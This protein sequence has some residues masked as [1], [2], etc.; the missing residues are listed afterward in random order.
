[1][2]S[3]RIRDTLALSPPSVQP[4]THDI[5][6]RGPEIIFERVRRGDALN[7]I[8]EIPN[9]TDLYAPVAGEDGVVDQVTVN[10]HDAVPGP[11]GS[12]Q[13]MVIETK[14]TPGRRLRALMECINDKGFVRILETHS[15]LSGIIAENAT[16]ERDGST[17][18]YDGFWESSLTDSA[19]KGYPDASIVGNDSRIHTIDEILNVTSK[20]IIVDGDTG[21]DPAQFRYLVRHLERLG[22]SAV[23]I[24]DKVYPKRNSLDASASQ[25]LEDPEVFAS[26]IQAGREVRLSDDFLVIARLESLIAGVGLQDALDRAEQ[27][28]IAGADGIMIHSS[29]RDPEEILAFAEAYGPLCRRLGKRP[30]LVSVPTTYNSISDTELAAAGF[31]IVIHA[32]H[33]LRASHRAMK[34]VAQQILESDRSMEA[35]PF[36]TSTAEIFATVGFDLVTERDWKASLVQRLSVIIPAAGRDPAFPDTPKSLIQV[37]GR[38][39]LD[40][41]LEAVRRTGINKIVVVRG[42]EGQQFG[43]R[44]ADEEITLCENPRYEETFDLYSLFQAEQHMQRGFVLIYSDILFDHEIVQKLVDTGEDIVLA[45]DGSYQYHMH[46]IDKRLDLAISANRREVHHRSLQPAALTEISRL[47]K[48]IDR[49]VADYEFVGIAYFSEQGAKTLLDA[50]KDCQQTA[51]GAFHEAGSFNMASVTDLLQELINRDVTVHGLEIHKGWLEI[52]NQHDIAVAESEMLPMAP[53][54]LVAD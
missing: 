42:H 25:S 15:G 7:D 41:Q 28:I 14:V 49:E 11:K 3:L 17:L 40:Y 53:A 37:A 20:P 24:E 38:H 22:V 43:T 27:Y 26:K 31:N 4:S 1:M 5:S 54:V 19:T 16:V 21:G 46:E 51:R 36:I 32:N 8:S 10:H 52:H 29:K 12:E 48:D 33:M 30:V 6:G 44:Y 34:E 50:Y 39:I 35:D 2:R 18:E 23:I 45:M 47:G 13:V 9:P